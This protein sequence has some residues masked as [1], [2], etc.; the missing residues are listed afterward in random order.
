M[1]TL[2]I[3][4]WRYAGPAWNSLFTNKDSQSSVTAAALE[5][6]NLK[7]VISQ[8]DKSLF[9]GSTDHVLGEM[10][11]TALELADSSGIA[12]KEKRMHSKLTAPAGWKRVGITI[13]GA[14]VFA[15]LV[16]FLNLVTF[17][18]QYLTVDRLQVHTRTTR[19]RLHEEFAR[20]EPELYFQLMITTLQTVT[21]KE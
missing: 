19:K 12:I 14:G 18:E 20:Q 8:W 10:M 1:I 9:T 17:H 5:V 7:K 15:D 6:Y 11:E 21:V 4:V 3:I 2:P 16:K 13:T